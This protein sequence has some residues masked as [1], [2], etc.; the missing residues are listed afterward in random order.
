MLGIESVRCAAV[1]PVPTRRVAGIHVRSAGFQ[2]DATTSAPLENIQSDR[3]KR[4]AVRLEQYLF[5]RS[6]W[7]FLERCFPFGGGGNCFCERINRA[8]QA[9]KSF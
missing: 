7:P 4:E 8:V 1:L 5:A 6:R 3:A 2:P 9:E